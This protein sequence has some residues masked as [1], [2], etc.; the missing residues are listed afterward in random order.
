MAIENLK[1]FKGPI[2]PWRVENY[3]EGWR[4][5]GGLRNLPGGWKPLEF[6][7]SN[8]AKTSNLYTI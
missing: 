2:N 8:F 4:T 1:L 3:S 5:L 7:K 6:W